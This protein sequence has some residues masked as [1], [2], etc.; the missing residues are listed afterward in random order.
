MLASCLAWTVIG[1]PPP[2]A[3]A[4]VPERSPGGQTL[5]VP[6]KLQNVGEVYY[7]LP[8][9]G[10]QF[11]WEED[12]PLLRLVAKCDR[13]VGYI[14]APFELEQQSPPFFGGALRIPVA[15][16]ST[17]N[18][19]FDAQLHSPNVLNLGEHP[20]ILVSFAAA[21]SARNITKQ[22][23]HREQCEF[24]VTG[25]LTV[26]ERRSPSKLRPNWPC[27]PTPWPPSSS[28]PAIW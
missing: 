26:R 2:C 7:V 14:V 18:E 27:C 11:T 13:A 16:L 8:A 17:G 6:E 15:S 10:T 3:A 20:E 28:A 5:R 21:S 25:E 1:D 12:A 23:N 22:D 19:Q 24:D 9:V 4:E